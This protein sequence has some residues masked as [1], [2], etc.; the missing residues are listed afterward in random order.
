VINNREISRRVLE[1]IWLPS[2][3]HRDRFGNG[4]MVF[5]NNAMPLPKAVRYEPELPETLAPA[6]P[7]FSS[8]ILLERSYFPVKYVLCHL[9]FITSF[10]DLANLFA[11]QLRGAPHVQKH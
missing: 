5:E 2:G 11:D 9:L 8:R 6:I 7:N 1:W 3:S 4:C 10:E